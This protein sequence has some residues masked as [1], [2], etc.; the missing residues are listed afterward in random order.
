[1][2]IQQPARQVERVSRKLDL[3]VLRLQSI[4]EHLQRIHDVIDHAR[5]IS[6]PPIAPRRGQER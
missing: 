2:D 4:Q 6:Q 3:V 5:P 1:M